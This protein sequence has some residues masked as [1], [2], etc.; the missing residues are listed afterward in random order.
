MKET[1]VV[2]LEALERE[3]EAQE[4]LLAGDEESAK[5]VLGEVAALYRRSW[6]LAP[7][8]AY[9]RLA[10]MLQAAIL[11][12]DAEPEA[13]FARAEV[14]SPSSPASEWVLALAGLVLGD[15]RAAGRAAE[16]I[17]GGDGAFDRAADAVAALAAGDRD[18]YAAALVAIVADFE[19]RDEHLTGVAI[20]DTALVLERLAEPRGLA[21]R[22]NSRVMPQQSAG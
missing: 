10:G 21:V 13:A 9:G 14:R 4:L 15:Y 11:A 18:R 7:P 19:S 5:P 3:R 2:L 22:P 6:E 20:A 17:E 8:G 1:Q 12:G 16:R